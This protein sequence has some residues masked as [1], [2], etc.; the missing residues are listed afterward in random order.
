MA[1]I[2]LLTPEIANL[3]AAGEVVERP[4][5]V[6]KELIENSIDSG[7]T[8]IT[9]EIKKGGVALIRVSDNGCGIDK[10]DL[11]LSLKRH[12]TSKIQ[13]KDDLDSIV[14]L[15]FRGEALAAISSVSVMTIISKTKAA[16]G[17]SMLT[18]EAGVVVDLSEV[19]AAD[20]T[21]VVV[22]NLFYN[23][24]AR[25]KFLKKDST[26]ALNVLAMV[27]RVAL[28][29]P[30]ISFQLLI[31][32]EEK[33]KTPGDGKLENSVYAIYGKDFSSKLV[34]INGVSGGVKVSGFVGRSDNVK[35]NRNYENIFINNRYVKSVTVMTAL[36]KAFTSFIAPDSF[37]ACVL[38]IDIDPSLVDVNVHPTKLEVKFS[39]EREIFEAVYHTVK[40]ALQDE[41]YRP[42]MPLK[43]PTVKFN[44]KEA[45][46]EPPVFPANKP[47][48]LPR[49]VDDVPIDTSKCKVN[50]DR[51]TGMEYISFSSL[52]SA[53]TGG[54]YE[55][56]NVVS[57][58]DTSYKMS[59][60]E[61]IDLLEACKRAEGDPKKPVKRPDF[62]NCKNGCERLYE[63]LHYADEPIIEKP[64]K[65]IGELFD[66]YLVVEFSDYVWLVD[67]HAAHERII[68]E[69]LKENIESFGTT[70]IQGLVLPLTLILSPEELSAAI[71]FMGEIKMA[72]FEYT[73]NGASVDVSAVPNAIDI[74]DAEELFLKL[75]DELSRGVGTPE[76]TAKIRAEKALYQVACKAAIKGGR[77]YNRT[78]IEELIEKLIQLPDVTVC[79][80]GR[81]I[82]YKITK[83]ELDKQFDRLK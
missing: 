40:N 27:Q 5:S 62:S 7:A 21:T 56:L 18:A 6:L 26:E 3:I 34:R 13:N 54:D 53:V 68:F 31:D 2:N 52:V 75:L 28:S 24:P 71:D 38:F 46:P 48:N 60:A 35:K 10:D 44:P 77:I 45:F 80:H 61:S 58:Y 66:C 41:E 64:Y 25:R 43:R 22:E 49:D 8:K 23:V 70:K 65:L 15:G 14:T 55:G 57:E 69:G 17:A 16:E 63:A 42:E 74:L 36:E 11:P 83:T 12:A 59:A 50:T 47:L 33:F 82:A 9:A 72:G 73:V 79:P 4:S 81:P 51:Q 29:R 39:D 30:D 20:G 76:N 78:I 1:K 37:P 32:G 67:K 19:S